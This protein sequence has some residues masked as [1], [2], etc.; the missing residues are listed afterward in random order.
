M[1]TPTVLYRQD[2]HLRV[3]PHAPGW[4]LAIIAF[5]AAA[6]AGRAEARLP[7]TERRGY[8]AIA[9]NRQTGRHRLGDSSVRA[10]AI[11]MTGETTTL[12]ATTTPE[13][14]SGRHRKG[15]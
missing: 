5:S 13:P 2:G 9:M 8:S 12:T 11:V 14:S 4:L 15:R 6:G 1:T 3:Q 10:E 7:E